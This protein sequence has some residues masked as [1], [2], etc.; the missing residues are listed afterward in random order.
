M[1]ILTSTLPFAVLFASHTLIEQV[2]GLLESDGYSQ[3]M[4][5]S[6]ARRLARASEVA[7]QLSG[8]LDTRDEPKTLS[9]AADCTAYDR[10][11][12]EPRRM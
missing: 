11:A 9:H 1:A 2:G 5:Q 8:A 6:S 4:V 7:A 10:T 12:E 3:A